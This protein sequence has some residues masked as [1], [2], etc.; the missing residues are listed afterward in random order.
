METQRS[1][2]V[3]KKWVFCLWNNDNSD[4]TVSYKEKIATNTI[5]LC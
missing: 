2:G 3:F 1:T 5:H 4:E